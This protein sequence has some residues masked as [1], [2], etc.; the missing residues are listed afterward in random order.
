M[1]TP[2]LIG[3]CRENETYFNGLSGEIN[4]YFIFLIQTVIYRTF[5]IIRIQI[6]QSLP[7]EIS[8]PITFSFK[9]LIYIP[10]KFINHCCFRPAS[11]TQSDLKRL[12]Q[13]PTS[14]PKSKQNT[15]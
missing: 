5:S 9:D 11:L 7:F 4:I 13:M 6:A 3:L 1:A 8:I 2:S 12:M 14:N 15:T 10:L